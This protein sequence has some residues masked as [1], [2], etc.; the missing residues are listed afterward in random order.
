MDCS[1]LVNLTHT[2]LGPLLQNQRNQGP[3]IALYSV[4]PL[5]F[6]RIN[7]LTGDRWKDALTIIEESNKEHHEIYEAV[8]GA[9][10][11]GERNLEEA[12]FKLVFA[13]CVFKD[14]TIHERG[15]NVNH[16]IITVLGNANDV[17]ITNT[18]FLN[19]FYGDESI[20]VSLFLGASKTSSRKIH[21]LTLLLFSIS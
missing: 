6:R 19:N 5:R 16:G 12:R 8:E 3:I 13:D 4:F 14:N 17:I 9:Q 11:D 20:A 21:G 10:E 2:I 7:A 15:P 1:V 18:L